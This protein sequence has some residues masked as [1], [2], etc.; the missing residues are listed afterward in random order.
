MT[1]LKYNPRAILHM[2][3]GPGWID[4]ERYLLSVIEARQFELESAPLE[5]I[6]EIQG[7]ISQLR[8]LLRTREK[9]EKIIDNT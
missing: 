6:K 3:S 1:D 7:K 9:M 8:E 5:S 2:T 4:F